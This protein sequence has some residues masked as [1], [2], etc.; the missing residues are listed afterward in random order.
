MFRSLYLY[1][2][3]AVSF[4][5][6]RY[7]SLFPF[8]LIVSFL[9]DFFSSKIMDTVTLSIVDRHLSSIV[10]TVLLVLFSL[11]FYPALQVGHLKLTLS[12]ARKQPMSFLK[13]LRFGFERKIWLRAT[14]LFIFGIAIFLSGPLFMF[15]YVIIDIPP[16][17]FV[18]LLFSVLYVCSLIWSLFV[19]LY[20]GP[21]LCFT[22][23]H[24][25]D[26]VRSPLSI[27]LIS[28]NPAFQSMRTIG[29]FGYW[30]IVF[31]F[32][33]GLIFYLPVLIIPLTWTWTSALLSL[34]VCPFFNMPL[35]VAYVHATT[36]PSQVFSSALCT[37]C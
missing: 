3:S 19:S 6:T 11:V 36:P 14:L 32:L 12:I 7:W 20:L 2:A 27:P 37:C 34:L 35:T 13:A 22:F 21:R 29:K 5:R 31:L 33:L 17:S 4:T 8:A 23:L 10:L 26:S 30:K 18:Q 25:V 28:F 15:A 16:G 24:L 1:Y 9:P